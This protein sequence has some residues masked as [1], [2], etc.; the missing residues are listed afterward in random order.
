M[1][2][3]AAALC[4]EESLANIRVVHDDFFAS[5]LPN[6]HV[7]LVHLRFQIAPIGRAMEQVEIACRLAK[8]GGL[9]VLEDPE[10][11]T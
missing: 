5:A 7:D 11:G 6:A 10:T 1:L 3:S 9:V 4:A 2:A 8:P